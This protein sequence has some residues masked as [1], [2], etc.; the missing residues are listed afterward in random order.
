MPQLIMG[1]SVGGWSFVGPA[2][3]SISDAPIAT[4][5][6]FRVVIAFSQFRLGPPSRLIARL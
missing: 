1:D 3:P 5:I 6:T 2:Q 4:E